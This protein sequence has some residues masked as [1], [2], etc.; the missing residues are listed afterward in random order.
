MSIFKLFFTGI[1]VSFCSPKLFF[2]LSYQC[3]QD[4]AVILTD[5]SVIADKM[6]LLQR[7]AVE[8]AKKAIDRY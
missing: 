6:K 3:G 4:I 1:S 7:E 8:A 5:K 2:N